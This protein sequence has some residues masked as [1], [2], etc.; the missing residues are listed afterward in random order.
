MHKRRAVDKKTELDQQTYVQ[1]LQ[2]I[3]KHIHTDIILQMQKFRQIWDNGNEYELFVELL[4]CILT[5][6]SNAHYCWDTI[7]LMQK[8][9]LILNGTKEGIVPYL[10]YARF[11]NKKAE[12][13]LYARKLLIDGE[14]IK[15]KSILSSFPN[16]YKAREWLAETIKGIG[17]KEASHFLRNI[18][19]GDNIAILDR[20]ILN[21]LAAAHIIDTIPNSITV[22]RYLEIEK[23]MRTFAKSIE[24]P[25]AHLD[26]VMWY[27]AKNEIFK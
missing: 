3:Y 4:F 13:I 1:E 10:K 9:N 21:G 22:K 25:V 20:H 18:G 6:Q 19:F 14:N 12:N 7:N 17:Y 5:P 8:D 11:K 15:L 16:A 24:M 2:S 27:K 23:H 26:F